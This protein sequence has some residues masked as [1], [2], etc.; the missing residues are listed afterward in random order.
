MFFLRDLLDLMNDE[1][2]F[3]KKF[4]DEIHEIGI[5]G[6]LINLKLK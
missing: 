4:L 1:H 6:N 3:K 5:Y 2:N